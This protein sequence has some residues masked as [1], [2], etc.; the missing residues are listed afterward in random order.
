MQWQN[1]HLID[2]DGMDV[3]G[4]KELPEVCISWWSSADFGL[5]IPLIIQQWAFKFWTFCENNGREISTIRPF[6]LQCPL[7]CWL[8]WDTSAFLWSNTIKSQST[9][10]SSIITETHSITHNVVLPNINQLIVTCELPEI[11]LH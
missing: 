3:K 10:H 4:E 11:Y 8:L 7:S 6:C 9:F 2:Y 5:H 1:I